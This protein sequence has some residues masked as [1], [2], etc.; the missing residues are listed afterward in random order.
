MSG[1]AVVNRQSFASNLHL[2]SAVFMVVSVAAFFSPQTAQA[3]NCL[4]PDKATGSPPSY[5]CIKPVER[6]L[7][8]LRKFRAR[9]TV[10]ALRCDQQSSYNAIVKRHERELV[11]HGKGLGAVFRR[12]HGAAATGELNRYV[13]HLTNRAS[14]NSLSVRNYCHAMSRVF[15]EALKTPV[16]GLMAF[17]GRNPLAQVA[18]APKRATGKTR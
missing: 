7:V 2:A 3:A 17:I 18:A 16:R 8:D 12:L 14:I 13:T 4:Y 6:A 1:I 9:I 15:A 5:A 10:A 11:I